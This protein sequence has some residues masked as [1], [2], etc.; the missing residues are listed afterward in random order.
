MRRTAAEIAARYPAVSPDELARASAIV[1][2]QIQELAAESANLGANVPAGGEALRGFVASGFASIPVLVSIVCGLIS[3][4]AVPG[5]LVTR[6]LRHAV[7]RRDGREI[8]RARSAIRFLVAWSPAL[9]WIACVGVPMF[10]EPRVSPDVA[11][12]VGS[13]AFLLMAAG[14]AWTIAVPAADRTTASPARGL[15]Q[16]RERPGS[17]RCGYQ[18][19]ARQSMVRGVDQGG[20]ARVFIRIKGAEHGFAGAAPADLERAYAAMMLWFEQ[21]LGEVAR[22]QP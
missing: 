13:L 7:V 5:G 1:A 9:A 14:A 15:C 20:R 22:R 3:V 12:V 6:A 10:G 17:R 2:P 16:G 21:H 18:R 11:F 19:F 8:G 4:L